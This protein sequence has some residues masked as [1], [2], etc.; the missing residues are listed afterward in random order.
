MELHKI[1]ALLE[2]Y[3]EGTTSKT[4]ELAL[5]EFF[6]NN[7]V[8][9]HLESFRI[10]FQYTNQEKSRKYPK[11]LVFQKEQEQG[12][13]KRMLALIG[14]AASI[15]LAFGIFTMLD[16]GQEDLHQQSLGTIE[17]PEEAYLKAKE[18]LQMVS[19]IFNSGQ[20]ELTYVEEFD[21]AKDKYLID[22]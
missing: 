17:D 20:A 16:R 11:E 4:E 2:K 5:K 19:Q 6:I 22:Y 7:T 13:R 18:T 1:E 8:P 15:L 14:L 3:E 21:K 9:P 12:G 10:L